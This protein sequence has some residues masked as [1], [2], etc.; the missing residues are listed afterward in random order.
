VFV[1]LAVLAFLP[2]APWS[3]TTLF[4]CVCS[5]PPQQVW[6]LSWIPHVIMSG[7]NPFYST[8][9]DSPSGANML[10]N[11]SMMLLS[12]VL[13]PV[14]WLLGPVA[15]ANIGMRLAFAASSVS[16]FVVLRR[17]NLCWPAAFVGGLMYGFSPYMIGQATAHLQMAFVV[18]PPIWLFALERF[19]S[20]RWT[21]RRTGLWLGVLAVIQFFI[22]VDVLASLLL[23]SVAGLVMLAIIYRHDVKARA[24]D[25]LRVIGWAGLVSVPLLAFP[26]GYLLAGPGGSAGPQQSLASLDSLSAD[27]LSV[28]V[29]TR[30]Q[31]FAPESWIALGSSFVGGS[32]W[33]NGEYLGIPLLLLLTGIVAWQRRSRLTIGV[34]AAGAAA[35]ILTLGPSLT[36]DGHATWVTLPFDVLSHLPLLRDELPIRYSLYVQLAAAVLIAIGL[37]RAVTF[38]WTT[39]RDRERRVVGA[40]LLTALC[41]AGLLP[42]LPALPY[43]PVQTNAPPFFAVDAARDIP[44]ESNVLI[45]PYPIFPNDQAMLWQAASGLSFRLVGGYMYTK[46]T[47]GMV[48]LF[49][50]TLSP[51]TVQL[52][53]SDAF[54]G[55]GDQGLPPGTSQSEAANALREFIG[56]YEI[57]AVVVVPIGV[58]P[59]TVV[60]IVEQA[61]GTT[62]EHVGGVL[63]WRVG[64]S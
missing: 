3:S 44:Y 12:L 53:F 8:L 47:T 20:R 64:S 28:V 62:P 48:T 60:D 11:T 63:L 40:V 49:P 56:R 45:Y 50:P 22:S 30:L 58:S 51:A 26:A 5:D 6:F 41:V 25:V 29:P 55:S 36:V 2:A 38:L 24:A 13:A 57:S 27:L 14:T 31:A 15:A 7:G 19:L 18:V 32:V 33:E 17:W 52:T 54:S 42:L 37:D 46:T 43:E 9:I 10:V 16:A 21:A 35:F 34:A 61:T 59:G 23:M 4:G 1:L 39:E